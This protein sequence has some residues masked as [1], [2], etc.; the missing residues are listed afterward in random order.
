MTKWVDSATSRKT[1]SRG[2]R[3]REAPWPVAG[4]LLRCHPGASL[5]HGPLDLVFLAALA[6]S[7][8]TASKSSKDN[9]KYAERGSQLSKSIKNDEKL[10]NCANT[11]PN[12]AFLLGNSM[13]SPGEGFGTGH[14]LIFELF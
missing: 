4:R 10:N 12:N 7:L 11:H 3:S 2:P 8:I 1:K 9:S 13:S 5:G 14:L 6:A